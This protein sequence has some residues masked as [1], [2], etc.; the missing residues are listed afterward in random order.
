MNEDDLIFGYTPE[1]LGINPETGDFDCDRTIDSDEGKH[2]VKVSIHPKLV[3]K[4]CEVWL[5]PGNDFYGIPSNEPN[6]F[7]RLISRKE[8]LTEQE[9]LN[10]QWS[11]QYE[12]CKED[13]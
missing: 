11:V 2:M 4:Y 7:P 10:Y 9:W 6:S 5:V 12:S 8:W 1:E 13:E 3:G